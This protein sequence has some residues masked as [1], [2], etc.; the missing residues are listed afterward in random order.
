MIL[1]NFRRISLFAGLFL[2]LFAL[3]CAA[4][5][6]LDAGSV[7]AR[8]EVWLK[9]YQQ[10]ND[11]R[12]VVLIAQ[13]EKVLFEKAYGP[14]DAQVGAPNRPDTRFRIASL[15]KTFTAAAIEN[16]IS[17]GKLRYVDP[18]SKYVEG[19]PNGDKITIEELLA[20]SSGVG[21]LS[22]ED[23]FR[24]CLSRQEVVHRLS[25]AKP[26]FPPESK[27]EYSNEG[28]FLL[29]TVIERASG[30]SYADF[31]RQNIFAELKMEDSGTACRDLPEGRN[32]YGGIAGGADSDVPALPFNE[33]VLDGAG[34]GYSSARDLYR[35]LRAVDTN[36][37]FT[38]DK[39]KYPYGWGKRKYGSRD[40][41]E[42]SGQLAGFAAHAAIYPREHIYAVV[43]SNVQSG[44]SQRIAQDLE[45][46]LFGGKPS[47]PPVVKSIVLGERS[48]WQYLGVYHSQE[49]AYAQTFEVHEGRLT[50]HWGADPFSRELTMTDGDTF[51]ARADYAVVRFARGSDGLVH[52][53]TWNWPSGARLTLNKDEI[54]ASPP[55]GSAQNPVR[56]P[57]DP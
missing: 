8:A 56:P 6:Q 7:A 20:H 5:G 11:F 46:V 36:T 29:A 10:A 27:S 32:A 4:Q 40:L 3:N 37:K 57:G 45:T 41:I 21:G 55:P 12:G 47:A 25:S 1:N 33:A 53:I 16:L 42:Q 51:F 23:L 18:L 13:G 49:P 2:Q 48:M 15:S 50:M 39:L 44:F 24:E 14:A 52:S 43:L 28:Y 38:V 17:E 19:I 54:T 34:S 35:W 31:L 30:I 9:P 22:G 26:H